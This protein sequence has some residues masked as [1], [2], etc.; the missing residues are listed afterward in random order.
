M[1]RLHDIIDDSD[2]QGLDQFIGSGAL[3][4]VDEKEGD[5]LKSALINLVNTIQYAPPAEKSFARKALARI[6][7]RSPDNENLRV[8]DIPA[9]MAA[10]YK[11]TDV[12][13]ALMLKGGSPSRINPNFLQPFLRQ[14]NEGVSPLLVEIA[15]LESA[16]RQQGKSFRVY[17]EEQ[18]KTYSLEEVLARLEGQEGG[19]RHRRHRTRRHR[20][21]RHR[22]RRHR[23]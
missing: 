4:Q 17:A 14:H 16:A 12:V 2:L 18:R 13:L 5:D 9:I 15:E 11:Q 10:N 20:T 23:R 21:R 1:D 7:R 22:T 3:N 8:Y 19:R 6:L